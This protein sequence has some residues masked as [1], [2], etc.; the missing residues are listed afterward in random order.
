MGSMGKTPEDVLAEIGFSEKQLQA[1]A[2][3][4]ALASELFA[5]PTIA[6]A[7]EKEFQKQAKQVMGDAS[8][9]YK[10]VLQ[11][12]HKLGKR[13]HSLAEA[14]RKVADHRERAQLIGQ[15]MGLMLT[16]HAGVC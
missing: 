8:K 2:L 4:A 1:E 11:M 15:L 13:V 3:E 16:P 5:K 7:E 9:L 10:E 14:V 6:A 12:Q